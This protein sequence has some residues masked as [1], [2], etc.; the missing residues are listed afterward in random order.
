MERERVLFFLFFSFSSC[1]MR[2]M[3]EYSMKSHFRFY[4]SYA[5]ASLSLKEMYLRKTPRKN[6]RRT[7]RQREENKIMIKTRATL[8]ARKNA[9]CRRICADEAA[10]EK[11]AVSSNL[12]TVGNTCSY[13]LSLPFLPILH[14]SSLIFFIILI[15]IHIYAYRLHFIYIDSADAHSVPFVRSTL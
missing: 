14:S 12:Q 11:V 5:G 8:A 1:K 2:E 10:L 6:K 3:Y 15:H 9:Y 7:K 4:A 13:Y